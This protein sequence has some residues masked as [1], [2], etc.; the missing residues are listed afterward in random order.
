MPV[1]SS[2]LGHD[3]ENGSA[4]FGCERRETFFN[5]KPGTWS[6]NLTGAVSGSCPS[7]LVRMGRDTLVRIQSN[8][9]GF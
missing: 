2:T 9:C 5:L 6:A 1:V 3:I 8:R 4:F 7:A